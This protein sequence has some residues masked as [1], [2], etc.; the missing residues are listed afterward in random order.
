M[1]N[2]GY[3]VHWLVFFDERK[4]FCWSF[5]L[6]VFETASLES[7]DVGNSP[8][9]YNILNKSVNSFDSNVITIS[10]FLNLCCQATVTWL[11]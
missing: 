9:F 7:S 1:N 11:S 4:L 10:D 6:Y 3:E 2:G 8:E 5:T